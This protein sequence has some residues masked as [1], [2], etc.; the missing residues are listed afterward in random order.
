MKYVIISGSPKRSGLCFSVMEEAVRGAREGGADVEVL[1]VEKLDRCH[2]CGDGWGSCREKHCCM[3]GGDGF[4]D[5]QGVMS[6]RGAELRGI[7]S[8]A[9]V[10]AEA[11]SI[12]SLL[13]R[14]V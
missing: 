11:R 9:F 13:Y 1:T 3:F 8:F 7:F 4:A 10:R 14:L 2:V 5:I 12:G 6:L